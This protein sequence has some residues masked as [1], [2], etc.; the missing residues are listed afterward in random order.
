MASFRD[1]LEREE[2]EGATKKRRSFKDRLKGITDGGTSERSVLTGETTFKAIPR[3]TTRIEEEPF[4]GPVKP[5][6][7]SFERTIPRETRTILGSEIEVPSRDFTIKETAR[8]KAEKKLKETQRKK[9]LLGAEE[10]LK[11]LINEDKQISKIEPDVKEQNRI[12]D[13]Y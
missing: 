8:V 6:L 1:R 12:R 10:R 4:V 2:T 7:P 13:E 5:E 3:G 11:T 9:N